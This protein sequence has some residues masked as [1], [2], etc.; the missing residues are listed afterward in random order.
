MRKAF[1]VLALFLIPFVARAAEN[2]WAG[3][4]KLDLSR[5]SFTGTTFSYSKIADGKMQYDDGGSAPFVFAI[6]GKPYPDTAGFTH[7]WT[8]A[9]PNAWDA[10]TKKGDKELVRAHRVLSADG[11]TLSMTY[12]GTRPDGTTFHDMSTYTRVSGERGL[13]G[14][15]R[16]TKVTLSTPDVWIISYPAP[17][18]F[19]WETPAFKTVMTGK[20]DGSEVHVSSPDWPASSSVSVVQDSPTK[21]TSTY[22]ENGK[23]TNITKD[24][25]AA[26]AK[27]ITE[28]SWVPGKES[29]KQTTIYVKQ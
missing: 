2:P 22:K 28:E 4:W 23:A 13:E 21:L 6:D 20:M 18:T 9:E 29:E 7:T 14:T 1:L 16:A 25:L 15:W 5:S 3:T 8:T 10:V 27:T 19:R 26:D 17:D 11:K 24:N 12:A